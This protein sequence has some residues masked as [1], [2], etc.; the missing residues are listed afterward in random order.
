MIM[1]RNLKLH[2]ERVDLENG[3]YDWKLGPRAQKQQAWK[4]L[5]V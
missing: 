2:Q 1:H 3:D 4:Q 5:K